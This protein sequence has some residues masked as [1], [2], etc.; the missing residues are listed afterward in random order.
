MLRGL[1]TASSGWL[2]KTVMA[3]VVGLLVVAFGIWGIGDIFRSGFTREAVASVGSSKISI[4]Q[5]RQLYNN[6]LQQISRQ[7]RRP[8]TPEQA[9][10]FGL[11]RQVLGQ[12]VQEAALDQRVKDMRLGILEAEVDRRITEDPSFRSKSG[13]FDTLQFEMILRELGYNQQSYKAEQRREMLR[14]QI[15]STLTGDIKTPKSAAEAVNRY[16]NEQREAEYVV[17]TRAQAGDIPPPAP[18]VLAKYFDERKVL[19][20]APEYRKATI[21]SLVPDDIAHSIEVSAADAKAFYDSNIEHYT[22]PEK[23]QIQQ[24]LFTDKEEAHKA[25]D[26]LKA[27]LS[28]DDLAKERNLGDTNKDFNL[29]LVPKSAILDQKVADV[30][31]SLAAG[32]VS[33][34]IDAPF[35]ATIVRVLKIEPGSGKPYAEIEPEIKKTV[36]TERAKQEIRKLRDKVDEEIGG[37]ARLDEIAKKLN[38]PYRSVE[39]VD[40]SGRGPDGKPVDLPAGVDVLDGIFAAE[41]GIENDALQ[42]QTGGIV[43]Y[44]LVAITPSRERTLDEVKDQVEA[45]WRDDQIVARLSAKATEMVDKINGGTPLAQFAAAEKL[46]VEHSG[47]LKRRSNSGAFPANPL[48]ALFRTAKGQAASAEGKEPTERFVFVVTNV[49]VPTFDPAAQDA[50]Q[51]DTALRNAMANDLYS[52]YLAQV[53]SDVGVSIDQNALTQALGSN[54]P[55]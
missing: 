26:R 1:R 37:G 45:R 25:A 35:S 18:D 10:A 19:F 46:N 24:I 7:V 5:F 40:R 50:K 33:G 23:R 43:W 34:S 16:E 4:E 2:G 21:L 53:E 30:A 6:K 14:R 38:L 11:D 29:G 17:L 44:D 13:Q 28:F 42:S 32:E 20:R 47:W 54:P 22:V 41:V 48:A 52:Q 31:F 9:R 36:A 3:V 15:T 12:W 49:M 27:G 51:I 8:I 39:A 55:Q